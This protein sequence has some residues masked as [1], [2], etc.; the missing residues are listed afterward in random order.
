M[1][2]RKKLFYLETE[3]LKQISLHILFVYS[4]TKIDALMFWGLTH[5]FDTCVVC[6]RD[7]HVSLFAG[8]F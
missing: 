2:A 7:I 5:A 6:I 1:V 3:T 8:S 4:L